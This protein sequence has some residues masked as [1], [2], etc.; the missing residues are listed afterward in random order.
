ME[1]GQIDKRIDFN[2]VTFDV[3]YEV[4][5][6]DSMEVWVGNNPMRS[7]LNEETIDEIKSRV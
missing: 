4:G 7:M 3:V 2:G 5:D 6:I 1:T